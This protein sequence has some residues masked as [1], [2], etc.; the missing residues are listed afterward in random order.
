MRWSSKL[1]D[2][3]VYWPPGVS[4][5]GG[6]L[7]YGDAVEIDCMLED[8]LDEVN[9][10]SKNDPKWVPK[11]IISTIYPIVEQGY[12]WHG[13]FRDLKDRDNPL[14]NKNNARIEVVHTHPNLHP[15]KPRLFMGFV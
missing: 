15:N 6:Q 11:S 5:G 14:K 9:L 10:S 13:R 7:T 12:F 4:T 2:K 1:R 3:G 8:Y